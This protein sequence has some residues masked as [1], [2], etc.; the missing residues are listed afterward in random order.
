ME[1]GVHS[2]DYMSQ[3][4]GYLPL[5]PSNYL[6]LMQPN[7]THTPSEVACRPSPYV[8]PAVAQDGTVI[9]GYLYLGQWGI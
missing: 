9:R 8:G 3:V 2:E 1:I 5:V 7:S 4:H 6:L